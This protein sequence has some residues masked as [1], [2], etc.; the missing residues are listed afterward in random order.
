MT[1]TAAP[2][3][4]AAYRAGPL[5]GGALLLAFDMAAGRVAAVMADR[6]RRRA[7][8][9]AEVAMVASGLTRLDDRLSV[10]ER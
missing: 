4:S 2:A 5:A 6:L 7:R 1:G 3:C 9:P 10:D 8:P